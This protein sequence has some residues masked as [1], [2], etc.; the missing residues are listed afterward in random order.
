[1]SSQVSKTLGDY[2]L[3]GYTMLNQTCP[4]CN[5]PLVQKKPDPKMKCV[6]CNLDVM[7]EA[8][9][10]PSNGST[11]S[12]GSDPAARVRHV[13]KHVDKHV[14]V[15]VGEA[16]D[17]GDSDRLWAPPTAEEIARE[18]K[19]NEIS[20]K[21]GAKLLAGWAMLNEYCPKQ[22][23]KCVLLRSRDGE[24]YCVSCEKQIPSQSANQSKQNL[25]P[26]TKR[27]DKQVNVKESKPK[28][29][30]QSQIS[31]STGL[32]AKVSTTDTQGESKAK[33]REGGENLLQ[34][35]YGRLEGVVAA[36]QTTLANKLE[37]VSRRLLST[38]DSTQISAIS[39]VI[40]D[41]SMALTAVQKIRTF[42]E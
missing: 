23:C 29:R 3:K 30:N 26:Q 14:D 35:S 1:M 2:L 27:E 32:D 17:E 18:K 37:E 19:E 15:D 38:N 28:T 5:C 39:N 42:E 8:E 13:D 7:T 20:D 12:A 40:A 6:S 34:D 22:T 16:V 9:S 36:T 10:K 25:A 41:L 11:G 24:K 4:V 31:T 21:I 33:G